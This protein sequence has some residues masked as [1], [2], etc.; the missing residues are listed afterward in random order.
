LA[1]TVDT[2]V[3]AAASGKRYRDNPVLVTMKLLQ[4]AGLLQS[5]LPD[6][7]TED[8]ADSE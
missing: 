7:Q 3:N 1:D 4:A 5:D 6:I 2:V 8:D